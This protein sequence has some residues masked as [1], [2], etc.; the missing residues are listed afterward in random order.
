VSRGDIE[1]VAGLEGLD[2]VGEGERRGA[3]DD[4]APVGA[5]T[6]VVFEPPSS[7]VPSTSAANE[8]IVTVSR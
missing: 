8:T 5:L 4:V 7:G 6:E 2:V 3:L 1:R